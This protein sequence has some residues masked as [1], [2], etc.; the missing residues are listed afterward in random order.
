MKYFL[1]LLV[2]VSAMAENTYQYTNPQSQGQYMYQAVPR[3][4]YQA[5]PIQ[6]QPQPTQYQYQP[7]QSQGVIY[8]APSGFNNPYQNLGH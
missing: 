7:T 8:Q 1:I 5:P 2:S 4:A 6:I 3:G